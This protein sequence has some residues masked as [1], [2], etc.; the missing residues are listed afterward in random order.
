MFCYIFKFPLPISLLELSYKNDFIKSKIICLNHK[1]NFSERLTMGTFQD[2]KHPVYLNELAFCLPHPPTILLRLTHSGQQSSV[3]WE[4]VSPHFL[5][6]PPPRGVC[7]IVVSTLSLCVL[8]SLR[9]SFSFT[10]TYSC[11]RLPS[12][13]LAFQFSQENYI[14]ASL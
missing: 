12:C 7:V 9:S 10:C 11:H 4:D 3:L 1:I 14:S 8:S 6:P 2:W 13:S 5:P